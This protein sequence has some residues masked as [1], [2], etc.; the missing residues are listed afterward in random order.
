MNEISSIAMNVTPKGVNN[1]SKAT[2]V[3]NFRANKSEEEQVDAFIKEQEKAKKSAKKQQNLNNAVQIGVL[4]AILASVGLTAYMFF[5]KGPAKTEFKKISSKMPSVKDGCVNPKVRDAIERFVNILKVPKDVA[6]YTKAAPPRFMIFYGP[7]GTGKT[8]SGQLVA[9]ELNAKY[10]EIQFS[11]LSSEYIGKTAVNISKKFAELKKLVNKNPNE[12]HV[13]VF[14]EMDSL[15]NNVNKLGSNNQHLG[16]NRTAFLNGLDSVKDCKNL[17]IIGTTNVNPKSGNVDL[18]S[19][20]RAVIQEI[21]LPIEEEAMYAFDFQLSK[22]GG[23]E[24][25]RNNKDALRNLAKQIVD[26]KGSNR[27]IEKIVETATS[28]FT[29]DIANKPNALKEQISEH[30][31]QKAIDA[32]EIWA[33]GI[34]DSADAVSS[35]VP[36]SIPNSLLDAFW[37]FI[38][39]H[40][41]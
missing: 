30:Y 19:L 35:A 26:K 6:N 1:L 29:I 27:D 12:Q 9:K 2:N 13:V 33:S 23:T 11:D 36:S 10:A 24:A 4:G 18:A 17:T 34:D 28:D 32:K 14:N 20:G 25:L 37:K 21:Q 38:A 7:T 16:Q 22:Y 39:K 15:L 3:V 41:V 8:F 40:T 5:G 31:L